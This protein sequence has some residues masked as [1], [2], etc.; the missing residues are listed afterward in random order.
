M[1]TASRLDPIDPDEHVA[2][3]EFAIAVEGVAVSVG[4]AIWL[5]R[6]PSSDAWTQHRV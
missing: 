2:S 1:R 3:L 5:A 4:V 6:V